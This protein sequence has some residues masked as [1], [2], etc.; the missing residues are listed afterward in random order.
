MKKP[1]KAPAIG[2]VF[3]LPYPFARAE[4]PFDGE[5]VP[6][7]KPGT[8][9]ENR[10]SAVWTGEDVPVAYS[11]AD[12]IGTQVLTVVGVYQPQGFPTRVFFTRSW[13]TPEGKAF[14]NRKCRAT[15]VSAFGT[16]T[17]G[18]RHEYVLE[19]CSCDGCRRHYDHRKQGLDA[20]WLVGEFPGEAGRA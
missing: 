20:A 13:V 10:H 1:T 7:W 8:R 12:A 19:G 5:D 16:L 9:S 18:Y 14:G 6:T 2:E 15:T 3:T 11:V 4:Y 17:G